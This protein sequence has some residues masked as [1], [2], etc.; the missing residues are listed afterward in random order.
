M[1]MKEIFTKKTMDLDELIA[2][3]EDT[4]E[5]YGGN[6]PVFMTADY[7]D[8]YHTTQAL[9]IM[10]V[11]SGDIEESGY[12]NSGFAVSDEEDEETFIFLQ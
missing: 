12:S 2:M 5:I 4:R 7:G 8:Y 11:D 1:S 3:L 9:P 6:T 10:D